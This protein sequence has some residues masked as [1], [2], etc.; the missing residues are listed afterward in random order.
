MSSTTM[1]KISISL[2][3]DLVAFADWQASQ[4]N[5]SRSQI[6]SKV[7]AEAKQREEERLAAEGYQFYAQEAAEFATASARAVAEAFTTLEPPWTVE[8]DSDARTAR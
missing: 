3:S 8:V 7:L 1:S 6:I 5:L 2:P 4:A